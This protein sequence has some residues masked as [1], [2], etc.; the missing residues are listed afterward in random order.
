MISR[1]PLPA[2]SS[3]SF[4]GQTPRGLTLQG[5]PVFF[6]TPTRQGS[7][8]R[9]AWRRYRPLRSANEVDTA[10]VKPTAARLEWTLIA[11]YPRDC[12]RATGGLS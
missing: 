4:W 3:R 8:G 6:G 7:A 10:S 1:L 5:A 12:E 11:F 2:K 9:A